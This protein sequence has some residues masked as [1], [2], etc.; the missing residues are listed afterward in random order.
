MAK[1]RIKLYMFASRFKVCRQ[2]WKMFGRLTLKQELL[3]SEL[4]KNKKNEKQS[5]FSVQSRRNGKVWLGF[6]GFVR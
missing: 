1:K 5:D 4:R 3:I 2:I 6:T